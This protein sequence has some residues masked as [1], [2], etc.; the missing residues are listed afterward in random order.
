MKTMNNE[1]LPPHIRYM[2]DPAV[3]PHSVDKVKLIQTHISFVFVAGDFVYKIKKSVDFGFLDFSTLEKRKYYCEQE[4]VLNQRLC[5][6]IY[7]EVV[8]INQSGSDFSINGPGSDKDYAVKM[9]RMPEDR[10]MVNVIRAGQLT[11]EMI[12]NIVD[13]LIPFYQNADNSPETRAYGTSKAVAVNVLENF[14][15]TR[16]YIGLK[17]LSK[18]QFEQ[19]SRYSREFLLNED[20]FNHRISKDRVRDC[21]GDLHSANICLADNVYI[22]DCIEFNKRLRYADVANDVAFLAMDLDFHGLEDLSARFIERFKNA[23]DDPGLAGVLNFYKCYRA[24]VRGKVGLFTAHGPEVDE[25]ERA[26]SLSL[27]EKYF[28]LAHHYAITC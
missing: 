1:L 3:Y 8:S 2:L 25:A 22:Y 12:D 24:Y 5:P 20:L 15:Q 18:E 19:I 21:H 10:M 13:A 6:K 27:A 23:S 28:K 16:E 17:A 26:F 7:L 14:E 9:V 11:N 4:V